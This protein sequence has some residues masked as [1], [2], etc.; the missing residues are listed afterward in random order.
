MAVVQSEYK[1]KLD[2][3][4]EGQ[5]VTGTPWKVDPYL[6]DGNIPFGRVVHQGAEINSC[7][8]GG[9]AG[10]NP[11]LADKYLG[12]AVRDIT[13]DNED[14]RYNDNAHVNV[15]SEGD[16][17][18]RVETAVVYGAI[19][20]FDAVTGQLSQQA[21]AAGQPRIPRAKWMTSAGAGALAVVRLGTDQVGA[22]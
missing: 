13:Q 2:K 8:V 16:I 11:F 19:V 18:V 6:A 17:A 20:T 4:R 7:A 5:I 9:E 15:A 14:G 21:A 1:E 22:A 10:P 12:I 3:Y